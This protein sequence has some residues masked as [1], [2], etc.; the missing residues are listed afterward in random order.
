[1]GA[2]GAADH[3]DQILAEWRRERPDLDFS[4][5]A[6]IARISRLSR[7]LERRIE[8]VLS[9]YGI[10]ESGFG[11]LA[12]LRRAGPP[13]RLTPTGLYNSLLISSGAMTNRLDR[14]TAADLVERIPDLDD[15]RSV[16][17]RLTTRGL[18]V[19]EEALDAHIENEIALLGALSARDKQELAGILRRLLVGFESD[20]GPHAVL[21]EDDAPGRDGLRRRSSLHPPGDAAP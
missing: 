21:D 20:A 8:T 7:I 1:M 2:S 13:Y 14:L 12:A 19:V 11:V 4:A 10:N 18:R 5:M 17:V 16:L 9:R 6:V 15:R 3:V